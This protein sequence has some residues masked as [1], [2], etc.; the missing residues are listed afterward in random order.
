VGSIVVDN[1][2]KKFRLYTDRPSSLKETMLQ[3]ARRRSRS[4]SSQFGEEHR[5]YEDFW[6]LRDIDLEIPSGTTFGL[7]GHNGSGKSTMLRMLCGIY[8]PTTGSISV[9]GR[10]SALL[11]LGAGF[12]PDLTG[13]ENV[14]LNASVLGLGKSE[15]DAVIDDIIDFSGIGEFIDA[16]VKVYSSGMYVRLG[17]AVSVHVNP[18]ILL[19]DEVV[20]VG[21]EEFQRK[22]F[23][24][25]YELRRQGVTIVLVSH[26]LGLVQTMCD[27]A[28]W[29]DRGRLMAVGRTVDVAAK[30]LGQVN[31]QEA[32]N[33]DDDAPAIPGPDEGGS[34]RGSGEVRFTD[35]VVL[36]D[37]GN[38]TMY[39]TT[40]DTLRIRLDFAVNEPV[41]GLNF[42]VSFRHE[43]G[44]LL[45]LTTSEA[46]GLTLRDV[47]EDGTVTFTVPNL[48]LYNGAYQLSVYAVTR[49][50]D[51]AY[52]EIERAFRLNVRGTLPPGKDGVMELGGS[53]QLNGGGPGA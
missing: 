6:A 38:R 48:P 8:Q 26:S 46:D 35:V 28:A 22:C 21:D 43:N 7:I 42:G 51:H 13:R 23:E 41:D 33:S 29:F 32:E 19:I 52:D 34:R 45:S 36:D 30:Y 24:H 27:N 17:F 18:E 9:A 44:L 50:G 3:L 40:G 49:A 20:A 31:E 5:R 14:Y 37:A 47:S 12:H 4:R 2:S 11:E 10:I 15:I 39:A 53:W 1:V 25:I 16:P